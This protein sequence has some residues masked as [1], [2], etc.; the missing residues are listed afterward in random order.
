[1][2]EAASSSFI[3]ATPPGDDRPRLVCQDCGFINYRNPRLVVGAVSVWQEKILL[4]RR[5]IAPREG[6]WTVP[7]GFMEL[8]ETLAE[9]AVRETWEEAQAKITIGPLL[10]MFEVPHI[11]QVH[12]MFSANM[13]DDQHA[14]G[15]ESLETALVTW[16]DIPWSDLAFPSVT[17]ALQAHKSALEREIGAPVHKALPP[18]G[19]ADG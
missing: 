7:A 9:G 4:A 16:D 10:G 8:S 11:G 18:M 19:L 12:V 14:P 2:S 3:E 1:M 6:Y 5:A 13:A 15:P 17:E